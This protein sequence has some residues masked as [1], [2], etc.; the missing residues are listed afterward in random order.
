MKKKDKNKIKNVGTLEDLSLMVEQDR[1]EEYQTD[2]IAETVMQN[3]KDQLSADLWEYLIGMLQGFNNETQAEIADCLLDFV[4]DQLVH[5][6]GFP[7]VDTVL[8]ACYGLISK[9]KGFKY[10]NYQ[11]VIH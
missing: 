7:S 11:Y 5:L 8:S 4:T 1:T 6:T 3:M 2:T 9:E 10:T